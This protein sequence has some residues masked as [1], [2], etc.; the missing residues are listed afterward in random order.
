MGTLNDKIETNT[1]EEP[2]ELKGLFDFVLIASEEGLICNR[3]WSWTKNSECKYIDIRIDM[4]DGG[5]I[6]RNR[7]GKRIELKDL[8]FQ[9]GDT[10]GKEIM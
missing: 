1:W 3:A 8:K 6:L 9:Y 4:R 10:D 5:F 2:S 7:D